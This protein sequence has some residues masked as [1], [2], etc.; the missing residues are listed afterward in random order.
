MTWSST[1]IK[2]DEFPAAYQNPGFEFSNSAFLANSIQLGAFNLSAGVTKKISATNKVVL[3]SIDLQSLAPGLRNRATVHD[4]MLYLAYAGSPDPSTPQVGD[5]RINFYAARSMTVSVVA[6]QQGNSLVP[7]QTKAGVALALLESGQIDASEMFMQAQQENTMMT[8]GLRGGGFF[9]VFMAFHAMFSALSKVFR[10]IPVFGG[11]A[12]AGATIVSGV[13]AV[14]ITLPTIAIAWIAYRPVIGIGILVAMVPVIVLSVMYAKKRARLE[15]QESMEKR[16]MQLAMQKG[17]KLTVPE[18]VVDS[19]LD[20]EAAQQTLDELARKGM[21]GVEVTDSGVI[22]Y[23]FSSIQH[24][25]EK[26][27]SKDILEA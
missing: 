16:I 21:A 4:G 20:I 24:L 9:M 19:N 25:G 23:V 27:S 22:V 3:Q 6:Q 13:L 18:V 5:L 26:A 2:S 14:A 10:R 7:Y 11:V 8:W 12:E 15:L 1:R 17:G